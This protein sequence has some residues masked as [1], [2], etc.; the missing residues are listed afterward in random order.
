M[1]HFGNRPT[2][3]SSQMNR[4]SIFAVIVVLTVLLLGPAG[5][6]QANSTTQ[7]PFSNQNGAWLAV[8]PAGGHVFVSGGPGTSSIVVLDYT[9]AIV[10]TITGEGGASQMALNPATHTLYVALHD[11]TAISEIDTQTLAETRRFSTAPYPNPTNLVIAGGKLWFS[12]HQDDGEGCQDIVSANLDGTGMAVSISG[13]F[14]ATMLAAG[15]PGGNLLA[16]GEDYEAPPEVSV[17]DVSGTTPTLVSNARP[18]D[19]DVASMTFDPAGTHLLLATGAPYYIQSLTT[20]NLL[21][22][23][24]YP[25]GPYPDAV[26]VTADGKFVAGGIDTNAGNDVFVYPVGSATPVRSWLVGN[27]SGADL[28]AHG[29]AFS[30]DASHL[31]AVTQNATTNH[32]AFDVL[33]DPT[34]HPAATSTTLTAAGKAVRYGSEAS[35]K[36]QVKGTTSGKVNLYATSPAN[37]KELVASAALSSG[38]ATFS[39]APKE[40]TNYSAVLEEGGPYASSVSKDLTV[41]VAPVLSVATRADGKARLHGHRVTKTLLTAK[42]KPL[43]PS[44]PL[45]FVVQRHAGKSWRIAAAGR[46]PIGSGGTVR[47]FFFTNKAG[48]CRVRVSYAGDSNY[49]TSKSGWKTFRTRRP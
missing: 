44:E 31:F 36:V 49:A 21:S 20:T 11:S 30:P 43:L 19:S 27:D 23:A 29:L 45:G 10:K 46:F 38:A 32:L 14:F 13:W 9:G 28:V 12:C 35:L 39:V 47:A 16:V 40:N 33:D 4:L 26:A 5:T 15:G 6:A 18:N 48:T 3:F 42:V 25:T 24:Q 17:Y 41:Q 22:S 7:L 34:I 2:S 37:V 1:G 8:D